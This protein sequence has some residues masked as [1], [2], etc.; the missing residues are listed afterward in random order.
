MSDKRQLTRGQVDLPYLE[1]SLDEFLREC[2]EIQSDIIK[3]YPEAYGFQ[4]V[5]TAH[6][7]ERD[8]YVVEFIRYENDREKR[9]REVKEREE[10]RVKLVREEYEIQKLQRNEQKEF[11]TYLKLKAKYGSNE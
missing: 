1:K 10:L 3:Q 2:Q 11:E 9:E 4:I 5:D 7:S 6:Y 8:N